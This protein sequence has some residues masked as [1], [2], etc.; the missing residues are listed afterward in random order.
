M[1]DWAPTEGGVPEP[2][3][4]AP[5]HPTYLPRQTQRP[6]LRRLRELTGRQRLLLLGGVLTLI[7]AL[8]AGALVAAGTKAT[9]GSHGSGPAAQQRWKQDLLP[10][11][12]AIEDLAAAPGLRYQDTSVAGI[13]ERDITVTAGGSRFGTTSSG[14]ERHDLNVLQIGGKSFSRWKVDPNPDEDVKPGTKVPGKWR[15]EQYDN[16]DIPY[17]KIAHKPSPPKLAAQL[18]KALGAFGDSPQ[19]D[20]AKPRPLTV[21]GTPALGI[22]TSAGRLL[23]TKREPHRVLRLEPYTPSEMVD[24]YQQGETEIPRVT[25]GP[26]AD[27]DSEGMELTPITGSAVDTMFDTLVKY[28]DQLKDATDEGITFSLDSAGD[29]QCGSSGCTASTSFTG[30]VY[31]KAKKRI[32]DGQ[33]TAVMTVTFTIGGKNAGRCTSKPVTLPVNGNRASGRLSCSN[34]GAGPVYTSVAAQYKAQAEAQSRASGGRT[35]R[36]TIPNRANTVIDARA[37]AA[38]EVKQLV[39]Q[40]QRERDTANC[41]K[42]HSS[43]SDTQ[44]LL[45]DGTHRAIEDIRIGDQVTATDPESGFIGAQPVTRTITTVNDDNFTR[46]IL[47]AGRGPATITATENH[48]FWLTNTKKTKCSLV[49][50]HVGQVDQDWVTKGAHVNMK[51]GMEVALRPDGKGDITGEA[52]RLKNGTANQKQVDAVIASIKSNPK[53]RADMI[54]VTESAKE[55]FESSAKAMK[56][57]RNPQWRFSNDRTAEL[58]ALIDAMEK[59]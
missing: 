53:L 45:A 15:V 56:E 7:L 18:A 34:P 36:Y 8:G 27:G 51:D 14:N 2:L 3:P 13:L 50:D 4:V 5:P 59:M 57:G 37:L 30:K 40:A 54:R 48:P 19:P 21:D 22:E 9:S 39:D 42:P 23:I 41:A 26:L 49:V 58:Q 55:V 1:T 52:I 12:Q 47:A 28:A 33:V 16:S 24:R 46:L 10:F 20:A 17:G 32:V 35:I 11:R 29:L 38:V 43:P 25:T 44:V 31:G 6:G